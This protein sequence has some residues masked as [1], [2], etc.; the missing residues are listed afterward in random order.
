MTETGPH[1]CCNPGLMPGEPCL[2]CGYRSPSEIVTVGGQNEIKQLRGLLEEAADD[3]TTQ[4]NQNYPSRDQ[5][6]DEMRRYTRDMDL[7][8]RIRD[9]LG[10]QGE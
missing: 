10:K 7:V 8:Y 6:P 5:Y 3:I 4:C 1:D 2:T 9:A